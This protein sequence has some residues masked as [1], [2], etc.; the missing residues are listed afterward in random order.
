M[1]AEDITIGE[2][3]ENQ[4]NTDIVEN[5][6][7]GNVVKETSRGV[8]ISSRTRGKL[9]LNKSQ[10]SAQQAHQLGVRQIQPQIAVKLDKPKKER[11]YDLRS[12]NKLKPPNLM[13]RYQ[14]K[15]KKV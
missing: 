8:E 12:K 11:E 14:G 6:I 1:I 9:I 15:S 7:D 4:D 5:N 10:L 3:S 2:N 13:M